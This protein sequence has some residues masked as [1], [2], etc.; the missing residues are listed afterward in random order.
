VGGPKK[1]DDYTTSTYNNFSTLQAQMG[2][3]QVAAAVTRD[4]LQRPK[5]Q[6][7]V[8]AE[9]RMREFRNSLAA[10]SDRF[11]AYNP[12]AI[13]APNLPLTD[14]CWDRND[15]LKAECEGAVAR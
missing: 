10:A 11:S 9:T 12:G 1:F 6:L 15:Q 13:R 8:T 7:H 2:F 5:G 14:Q 3:C 4:A